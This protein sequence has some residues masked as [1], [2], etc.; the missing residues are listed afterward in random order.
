MNETDIADVSDVEPAPNTGVNMLRLSLKFENLEDIL[1]RYSQQLLSHGGAIHD[2]Q[3]KQTTKTGFKDMAA[4]IDCIS[5]S[6]DKNVGEKG[7]RY[8]LDDA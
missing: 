5:N 2:L 6:V 1:D 3:T 7:H 4:F 8:K